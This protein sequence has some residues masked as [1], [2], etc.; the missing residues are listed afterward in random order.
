MDPLKAYREMKRCIADRCFDE[1]AELAEALADWRDKG[2]FRPDGIPS[3][4]WNPRGLELFAK[5]C[6]SFSIETR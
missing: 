1:A 5:L 3:D 6:R 4:V 2:G